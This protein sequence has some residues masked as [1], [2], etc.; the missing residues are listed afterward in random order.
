MNERY[1]IVAVE[2]AEN[3]LHGSRGRRISMLGLSFKTHTDHIR[4]AV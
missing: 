2:I 3:A 4:G 1:P